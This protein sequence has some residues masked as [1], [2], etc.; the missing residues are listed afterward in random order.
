MAGF[1]EPFFLGI[2]G[3][4][5]EIG[6]PAARN[7]EPVS[8]RVVDRHPIRLY[9]DG[10]AALLAENR[11]DV[12]ATAGDVRETRTAVHRHAPHVL[13]LDPAMP[14]STELIHELKGSGA[15]PKVVVFSSTPN[16][17][18]VIRFAE[19]GV[20]GYV[21]PE[22][23]AARVAAVIRCAVR[24]ELLCSPRVAGTLL[25]RVSALAPRRARPDDAPLTSREREVAALVGEGL[26]NQQIARTLCIEL[27]TV[28]NH[29]HHILEKL[30]VARRGEAVAQLRHP[31]LL[32][33]S[34]TA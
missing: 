2:V 27:P 25:R 26:S 6:E 7:E 3:R 8:V 1:S 30:E 29:V 10:L 33:G 4:V 23:S 34:P 14:D 9:R 32:P 17:R 22:C 12:L 24:G 15:E 5:A 28:K 18:D 13:V 11:V 31:G 16:E 20:A 21:T 19:A